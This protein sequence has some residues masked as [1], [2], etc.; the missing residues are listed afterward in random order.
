MQPGTGCLIQASDKESVKVL[1]EWLNK[2]NALVYMHNSLYDL[3]VLRSAGIE[4]PED[5][6][7]DSMLIAYNLVIEPQGLKPLAY[8]HCGMHQ[9]DYLDI[10]HDASLQKAM[11]Y[12]YEVANRSWPDVEPFV[13]NVAG[14]S[15]IKRPWNINR[16]VEKII[17]DVVSEKI[18]KDGNPANPRKRWAGIDDYVKEPVEDLLGS[19]PEATLDDV[20][21]DRAKWY[22]NR[23]SDATLRIAPIL[24]QRIKDMGLEEICAIDH[25]IIPMLDRMQQVGIKL[26]GV[27]F[28]DNIERK[29]EDQMGVAQYA[30]F[31]ETGVD[32]NPASGD[33]VADLLY[34]KLGLTPPK[35]TDSGERGSVNAV[36]L[37]SLLGENPVVQHIMDYNEANKIRGTYVKPLRKLCKIGDGRT[38][39]TIRSTR[40]TTGRL[41]MADPP[42]H[43]IPIMT[44]LGREL[45]AGF[46]AEEGKILGD[47][48]VD[49]LE[50]RLMAHDSK[51]V[52]LCRLFMEGRDV[53]TETACKIFSV[54]VSQLSVNKETGK[55]NDYR[56]TVAKHAAFG[57]I[58]GIT[59]HGMV[60][61]MI[62]N[63]C[64]RPDGESWTGDDCLNLIK[65]WFI[66][67]SGVKR[68]HNDCI[69][70]T[71]QTGLARESIGGRIIYLPQIWSPDKKARETAERMSYVMHTQGGGQTVIKKAMKVVWREVCKVAKFGA[72]PLLQMHDELLLEL[73]EKKSIMTEVD[74]LM[75]AA[76]TTTT[77]LR[78]PMK[79]S[80]GY[81][82]NWLEAH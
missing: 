61:Y 26:A 23:D 28:W 48:D 76:L 42:L 36:C 78:V 81:A 55:V 41:S 73:P 47:W 18:D 32:L 63:R 67:Y 7:R 75:V 9:D 2:S 8:R 65:E 24:E 50:M 70:E 30:I 77:K 40:T 59:E 37:E 72:E 39:S 27:E 16:R 62:L 12:L 35:L 25:A 19:M 38:R 10:I 15:K 53:H 56:R 4:I 44:D 82:Q 64:R 57:I 33:Q 51:D 1:N 31:T 11:E 14:V 3:G 46:I 22:A 29:C 54:P 74:K 58:N 43:Q 60:N 34:D 45:R 49:Q 6:F 79:A 68:F 17:M 21:Q 13:V 5:N 52:E 66:V 71:R 20:D 80:G 69:T